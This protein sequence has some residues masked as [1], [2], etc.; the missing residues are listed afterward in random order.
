M[1][2]TA[3]LPCRTP[4]TAKRYRNE[5]PTAGNFMVSRTPNQASIVNRVEPQPPPPVTSVGTGEGLFGVPHYD[6]YATSRSEKEAALHDIASRLISAREDER[7]RLARELHDDLGQKMALLSLELEQYRK[8]APDSPDLRQ[9]FQTLHDR[10]LEISMDIQRLS[11]RIHPMKLDYLGLATAVN[12]LCR[13]LSETG[14]LKIDLVTQGDLGQLPKDAS[15]CA[16]R[17][18]QEALRNCTKHSG[19]KTVRVVLVNNGHKLRLSMLDDGRGFDMESE[20]V[21]H[22]LGL[23]SMWERVRTVGGYICIRSRPG[24]GTLVDVSIPLNVKG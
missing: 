13:D 7:S 3:E 23:T 20:K 1:I 14:K 24:L 5:P 8:N 6:E 10:V 15:L 4:E 21:K 9:Q 22:G 17:I 18:V 12:S 2:Q 16:Y 19:A 11:H